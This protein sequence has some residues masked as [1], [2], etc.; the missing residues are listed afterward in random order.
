MERILITEIGRKSV[1]TRTSLQCCNE[2]S[3]MIVTDWFCGAEEREESIIKRLSACYRVDSDVFSAHG[4]CM[5]R[6]G[7]RRKDLS[8]WYCG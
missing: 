6:G 7:F 4:E 1:L 3:D 2:R 5:R 8:L